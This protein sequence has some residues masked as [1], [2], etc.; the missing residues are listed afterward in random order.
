MELELGVEVLLHVG[1]D[2]VANKEINYCENAVHTNHVGL[3]DNG[4]YCG[5]LLH[6]LEDG[7]YV[8]IGLASFHVYVTQNDKRNG[9]LLTLA[10]S[11]LVSSLPVHDN[12]QYKVILQCDNMNYLYKYPVSKLLVLYPDADVDDTVVIRPCDMQLLLQHQLVKSGDRINFRN[13]SFD[14]KVYPTTDSYSII[15]STTQLCILPNRDDQV[16]SYIALSHG[17]SLLRVSDDFYLYSYLLSLYQSPI[18]QQ[19]SNYLSVFI[20]NPNA[21]LSSLLVVSSD[22]FHKDISAIIYSMIALSKGTFDI[23]YLTITMESLL[24]NGKSSECVE[25]FY[26]HIKMVHLLLSHKQKVVLVLP[27]VDNLWDAFPGVATAIIDLMSSNKISNLFVIGISTRINNQMKGLFLDSLFISLPSHAERKHVANIVVNEIEKQLPK[28]IAVID[29]EKFIDVAV[30]TIPRCIIAS[31]VHTIVKKYKY[32]CDNN[33][34]SNSNGVIS[35][36]NNTFSDIIGLTD[37][38]QVLSESIIWYFVLRSC[39][40]VLVSYYSLFY[41]QY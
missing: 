40:L 30:D 19:L 5:R 29:R 3:V 24:T 6:S 4:V 21:Q 7:V 12:V 2:H 15:A 33:N 17:A 34:V 16:K 41:H 32:E 25:N 26:R 14:V 8:D 23:H 11:N 31:F 10:D 36:V 27:A 20:D 38:K 13:S 1:I 39:L 18:L 37:I 28:N 35:P 9:A 22:V